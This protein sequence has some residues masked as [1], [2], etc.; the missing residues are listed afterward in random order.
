MKKNPLILAAVAIAALALLIAGCTA[1]G[2][3]I[4]FSNNN[5]K[6]EDEKTLTLSLDNAKSL[7]VDNQTGN[8]S[9]KKGR[10]SSVSVK[11]KIKVEGQVTEEVEKVLKNVKT[12]AAVKDGMLEIRAVCNDGSDFW[13]WKQDHYRMLN[14]NINFDVA[15]PQDLESYKLRLITGNINLEGLNGST[16]VE[17]ITGN[18]TLNNVKLSGSNR[19]HLIT[20][21]IDIKGS[22]A[23]AESLDVNNTTGNIN[24][25]L[26]GDSGLKLKASIVTGNIDG[27]LIGD[28]AIKGIGGTSIEKEIGSGK[29]ETSVKLVTGNIT[30]SKK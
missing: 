5:V 6:Q 7:L 29:T 16:D 17:S 30:I 24:L 23:D 22:V 4:N 9:I 10:D 15:L 27:S 28:S 3:S 1:Q 20:G 12:Y 2:F 14:V 21:N 13:R 19:V 26:P 18:V 25:S 11:T 8:I